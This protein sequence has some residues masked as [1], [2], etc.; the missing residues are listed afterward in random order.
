MQGGIVGGNSKYVD[1]IRRIVGIDT[2]QSNLKQPGDKSNLN[3]RR[4]TGYK[5]SDSAAAQGRSS[6]PGTIDD[7]LPKP[8]TTVDSGGNTANP[9][10]PSDST[11]DY[12]EGTIDADD[13][14]IDNLPTPGIGG[15]NGDTLNGITGLLDPD[16]DKAIE[17]RFDRRA[18]PPEDWL[19][20][21]TPGNEYERW[22]L[23]Q[24]WYAPGATPVTS[25]T[26]ISAAKAVKNAT[27]GDYTD[28][29]D[30]TFESFPH[31]GG[32]VRFIFTWERPSDEE[33]V[34]FYAQD[35]S[36][37]MDPD[38]A[39]T[40]FDPTKYQPDDSMQLVLGGGVW[41]VNSKEAPEDVIA[42]YTDNQ[43]S[44]IDAKFGNDRFV[45]ILPT[46]NGGYIIAETDTLGGNYTNNK[47]L[48][49]NS[50]GKA[51]DYVNGDMISSY[52]P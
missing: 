13:N 43:H 2:N 21:N 8:A 31:A 48:L 18:R 35:Q 41:E 24:Y 50:Y 27:H 34:S 20:S 15:D 25:G 46:K 19:D 40:L 49:I 22:V 1:N 10:R 7:V 4:G 37:S 47:N 39:C 28:L 9:N 33:Q 6:E 29:V 52:L 12:D 36:C 44:R 30:A 14:L 51:I 42:S 38:A 16:T 26:A 3:A 5:I 23:G 11:N 17:L 32:S 45:S